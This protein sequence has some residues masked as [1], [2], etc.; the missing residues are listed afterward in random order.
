LSALRL[1]SPQCNKFFPK[2]L[3]SSDENTYI[4]DLDVNGNTIYSC[5]I[6]N[7]DM[8]LGYI[9]NN[10]YIAAFEIAST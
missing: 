1:S 10:P 3:G 8:L 4:N 9:G 5:G 2:I 6:I 7:S